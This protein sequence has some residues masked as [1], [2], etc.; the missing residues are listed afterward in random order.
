MR[1]ERNMNEPMC[2]GNEHVWTEARLERGEEGCVCG[3]YPTLLSFFTDGSM[4]VIREHMAKVSVVLAQPCQ[5]EDFGTAANGVMRRLLGEHY[6]GMYGDSSVS[7]A[8][9]RKELTG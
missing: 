4:T 2:D 9:P 8:F 3:R 7:I 6:G 5:I 1:M